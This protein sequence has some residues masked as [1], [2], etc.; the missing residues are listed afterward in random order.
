M[1]V[2]INDYGK[3]F[4]EDYNNN[5]FEVILTKYRKKKIVELLQKYPTRRILEVGCGMEPFFLNY[6][7]FDEMTVIEPADI[8]FNSANEYCKKSNLNVECIHDFVENKTDYLKSKH[9]DMILFIG[10]LHEVDNP[11]A[12]LKS[13]YDVCEVGTKVIILT[14]NPKSFH[15]TLAYESGL[16]PR[17]G[18][19]TPMAEKF[20]RKYVFDMKDM[21]TLAEKCGFKILEKGSHY[22]KPF[23]HNQM[24]ALI[25]NDIIPISVLDGLEK[26]VEY[27]PEMGAEI[28]CVVEK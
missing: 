1:S 22:V 21:L 7:D 19:I 20:Q 28:Y 5:D 16:I 8:L 3:H 18:I 26:M 27:M 13:V 12:V 11:F 9:Y 2:D 25:D 10:L 17:L 23:S 24:R 15:L 6:T 14:S 4:L